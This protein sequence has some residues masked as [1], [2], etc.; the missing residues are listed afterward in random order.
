MIDKSGGL[1]KVTANIVSLKHVDRPGHSR[2]ILISGTFYSPEGGFP[3]LKRYVSAAIVLPIVLIGLLVLYVSFTKGRLV[4]KTGTVKSFSKTSYKGTQNYSFKIDPFQ[5]NFKRSYR[6]PFVSHSTK[7]IEQLFSTAD[8]IDPADSTGQA[9][10]F[11]VLKADVEKL[12]ANK[13]SVPFFLIRDAN[14]SYPSLDQ[15]LDILYYGK[16]QLW[17]YFAWLIYTF[18]EIALLGFVFYY[19]KMFAFKDDPR[20]RRLFWTFAFLISLLNIPLILIFV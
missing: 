6:H 19:Y 15:F 8:G 14:K 5:S 7:H 13:S 10:R 3:K 1:K 20:K 9:L 16:R 4:E 11:S 18:L 17:W 2:E 12:Q